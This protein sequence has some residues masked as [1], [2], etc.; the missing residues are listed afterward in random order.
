MIN[1]KFKMM[2]TPDFGGGGCEGASAGSFDSVSDI[3]FLMLA[4]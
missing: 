3:L 1:S 4:D 2:V